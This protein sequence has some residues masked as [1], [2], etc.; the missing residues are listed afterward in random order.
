MPFHLLENFPTYFFRV[1]WIFWRYPLFDFLEVAVPILEAVATFKSKQSF[2]IFFGHVF[3][4]RVYNYDDFP[5]NLCHY[6]INYS[7][8]FDYKPNTALVKLNSIVEM[9]TTILL[10]F[11]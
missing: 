6:C 7:I 5:K 2:F 8:S 9:L 10:W 11:K 4:C 1:W 3:P